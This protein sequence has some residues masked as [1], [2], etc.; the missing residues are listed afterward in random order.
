MG[1]RTIAI[2]IAIIL[3]LAA[4]GLVWWY[5]SSIREDTQAQGQT[6]S[7][8]VASQT[9]PARTTGEDAVANRLV[10]VKSVPVE[11]HRHGRGGRP[12]RAQRTRNHC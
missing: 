1:R 6:Q 3:A 8:L 12:G 2:V 11:R 5:V 10:E 4:A 7:V 9:I